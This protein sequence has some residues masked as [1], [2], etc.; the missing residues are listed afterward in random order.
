MH[1][2]HSI[3]LIDLTEAKEHILGQDREALRI[4]PDK[5][6]DMG[7]FNSPN[8]SVQYSNVKK[9]SMLTTTGTT[10]GC[11]PGFPVVHRLMKS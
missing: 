10:K 7:S 3:L 2:E 4:S 9:K 5:H 8:G 1:R 11:A 6:G